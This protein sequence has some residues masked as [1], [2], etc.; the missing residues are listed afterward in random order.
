MTRLRKVIIAAGLV[1]LGVALAAGT[2]WLRHQ[3]LDRASQWAA[4]AGFAVST[5][6]GIAGVLLAWLTL[7]QASESAPESASGTG[8]AERHQAVNMRAHASGH[9]RVYQAGRDQEI[10]E[11]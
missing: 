3:G 10:R 9:G 11:R 2:L 4:V 7:R 6:L 1:A 8:A 5:A